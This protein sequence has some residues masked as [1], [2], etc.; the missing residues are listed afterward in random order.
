MASLYKE[1]PTPTGH[2]VDG[3]LVPV[4]DSLAADVEVWF[5]LPDEDGDQVWEC[6]A[7]AWCKPQLSVHI[8][9]VPLFAYDL[10]YGDE[11]GVIASAEGPFVATSKRADSGNHT[12]RVWI[13]DAGTDLS[14][15]IQQFGRLGC[16][17]EGYS[18]RLLGLSCRPEQAQ[19]VADALS[20]AESAGR[21]VYET[22]R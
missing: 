5:A 17:I 15:V 16:L 11:V 9:A 4:A 8:R 12:F 10:S 3:R 14:D 13:D 6:L 2:F 18:D 19:V 7:A 21:F 22:G 1:H 20:A